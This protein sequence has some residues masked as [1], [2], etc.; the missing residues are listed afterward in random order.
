MPSWSESARKRDRR[1]RSNERA[2]RRS[3]RATAARRRREWVEHPL[4]TWWRS[5]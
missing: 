4:K 5:R 3:A 2:H 1:A